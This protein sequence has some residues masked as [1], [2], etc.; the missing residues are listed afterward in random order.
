MW[1]AGAR[2]DGDP[3][4]IAAPR[5]AA[6]N[7]TRTTHRLLEILSVL[8]ETQPDLRRLA[9]VDFHLTND[10]TEVNRQR[11]EAIHRHVRENLCCEINQAEVARLVGL[12]PPAFS[13]FF[14]KATGRTFVGFVNILRI[15]AVCRA[16]T[17][18]AEGI[19]DIA[20]NSWL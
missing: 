14:R 11:I 9:S 15:N 6:E 18:S 12:T 16:M 4:A 17:E 13:R 7:R 2:A 1:L 8:A 10:I 3:D 20:M 19:T 5:P